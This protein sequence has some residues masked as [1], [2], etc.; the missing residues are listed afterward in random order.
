MFDFNSIYV[1]CNYLL[2]GFFNGTPDSLHPLQTSA[3]STFQK[4]SALRLVR[5][6][7]IY[8]KLPFAFWLRNALHN[9]WEEGCNERGSMQ[10]GRCTNTRAIKRYK[11]NILSWSCRISFSPFLIW[12]EHLKCE[13]FFHYFD[14]VQKQLTGKST[15]LNL[16]KLSNLQIIFSSLHWRR[17][18]YFCYNLSFC[19]LSL[20][21]SNLFLSHF[22]K[23]YNWSME[24]VII[25]SLKPAGVKKTCLNI[26]NG[27]LYEVVSIY[28]ISHN[29]V[30]QIYHPR[31]SS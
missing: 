6:K 10:K 18:L 23:S 31:F 5:T 30:G 22:S 17:T 11:R 21:L 7:P 8:K 29:K 2:T 1:F 4:K 12:K 27:R 16:S 19:V 26:S 15:N 28:C 9:S 13:L 3:V 25:S 24:A 14:D 20:S